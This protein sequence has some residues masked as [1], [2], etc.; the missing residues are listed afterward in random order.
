VIRWRRSIVWCV[1]L[2][3][4]VGTGSCQTVAK[5][6]VEG[7]VETVT[8]EDV[9][10][11]ESVWN[12]DPSL[13]GDVG[14]DGPAPRA[15]Y[16]VGPTPGWEVG[17]REYV[18]A[19]SGYHRN[20]VCLNVSLEL[21]LGQFGSRQLPSPFVVSDRLDGPLFVQENSLG[22]EPGYVRLGEVRLGGAPPPATI[23]RSAGTFGPDGATA[24]ACPL[25]GLVSFGRPGAHALVLR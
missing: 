1:S 2:A 24:G 25:F 10:I 3:A 5:Y 14:A 12:A 11:G 21:R 16:E 6:A 9:D 19:G 8:G 23:W 13:R 18:F 4:V 20:R 15:V 7:A 22:I 17:F